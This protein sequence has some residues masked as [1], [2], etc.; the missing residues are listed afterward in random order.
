VNGLPIGGTL[1]FE[2]GQRIV[3]IDQ[4]H[5]A[6]FRRHAGEGDETDRNRD[7]QIEAEPP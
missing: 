7:R 5:H 2:L 4:H 3:E 1:C 6:G